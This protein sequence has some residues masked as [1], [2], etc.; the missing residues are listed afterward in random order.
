MIFRPHKGGP[1]EIEGLSLT[2]ILYLVRMS[3]G[4][5]K[6]PRNMKLMRIEIVFVTFRMFNTGM[7]KRLEEL[8]IILVWL[9]WVGFY[10]ISNFVG[11]LMPN[12]I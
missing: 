12:L 8:E 6:K 4:P 10:G 3:D 2:L 5:A 1:A 11:Y 7:E 9:V